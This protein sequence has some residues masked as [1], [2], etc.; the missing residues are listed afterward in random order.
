[1][2]FQAQQVPV[3]G[4]EQQRLAKFMELISTLRVGHDMVFPP[5]VAESAKRVLD[6]P[7]S[8]RPQALAHEQEWLGALDNLGS[9][10]SGGVFAQV[11]L[12]ALRRDSE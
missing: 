8:R 12:K 7:E 1:M 2:V 5:L 11:A 9:A 3:S 10:V 4:K 6:T